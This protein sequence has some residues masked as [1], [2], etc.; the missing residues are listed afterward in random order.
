MKLVFM[1]TPKFAADVL[2]SLYS[3]G[4]DIVAVFCQPDK[5]GSRKKLE[6]CPAAI[7]AEELGIPVYKFDKV[8]REGVEVLKEISPDVIVT[9]AF[10]QML[11]DEILALPRFGVINLHGSL[12]PRFRGASP[13]QSALISGSKL[14]GVTVMK[15]VKK[16]DAGDILGYKIID[17]D[18]NATASEVFDLFASEGAELLKT[19]IDGLEKGEIQPIPQ[20]KMK[21][22]EENKTFV[23]P[24][25][26]KKLKKEDEIIDWSQSAVKVHNRIRGLSEN[27]GAFTTLNGNVLK[28]YR[29]R[30]ANAGTRYEKH[31]EVLSANKKGVVVACGRGSVEILSCCMAGG[32]RISGKDLANGKKISAGDVLGEGK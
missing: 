20:N 3:S 8:S 14:N 13:V 7:K 2:Y 15:T 22:L 27:P 1:G 28:I 18:K 16:M 24:S 26:C 19:V 21:Y 32:K 31:G 9:A 30:V 29:S 23:K 12:L 25:Y 5:S 4:L 6:E 11:S 10:G 17:T